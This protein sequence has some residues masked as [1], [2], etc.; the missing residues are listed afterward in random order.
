MVK[1][2]SPINILNKG[3]SNENVELPIHIVAKTGN[4]FMFNY[5]LQVGADTSISNSK[6]QTALDIAL[7]KIMLRV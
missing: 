5:L 6:K 3:K 4:T 2:K 1:Y 7:K